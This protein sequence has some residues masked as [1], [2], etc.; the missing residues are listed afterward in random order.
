MPQGAN[1]PIRNICFPAP[2]RAFRPVHETQMQGLWGSDKISGKS[3]VYM[4]V[5]WAAEGENLCMGRRR[6]NT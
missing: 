2:Q 1:A 6:S 5:K 3:E 4:E